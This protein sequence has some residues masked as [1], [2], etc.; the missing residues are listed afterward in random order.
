[1]S[2]KILVNAMAWEKRVA[3]I[4][5]DFVQEIH[6]ERQDKLSIIGNIYKG[7]VVRVLPGI[8]AAFIEIGLDRTAFLQSDDQLGTPVIE[9]QGILVQILKDPIDSKGARVTMQLAIS[10]R[11]LVF[12]PYMNKINIS[13]KIVE[14][15]ERTRL[16]NILA[17]EDGT[18]GG[19]IIRTSAEGLG[20]LELEKDRLYLQ[21]QWHKI[22]NKYQQSKTVDI[23][24][25]DLS[26]SLRVLRDLV[27]N[28]TSIVSTD[29]LEEQQK[30]KQ[31][32]VEFIPEFNGR[33]ELHV[34]A[35][36]IFDMYNIEDEIAKAL[37][38]KV[39]LKSGG[40]LIIEQA[41]AMTTIDVNSG[42]YVGGSN[43][44][45]TVYKINIEAASV[46][47]RQ[48]RLRNV[49]GIIII[50]F[51]DM[52]NVEHRNQVLAKLASELSRDYIK[53]AIS[54]VS[55]L[56]LVQMTRKRTRE[57]LKHL[58][59]EPC[60]ACEGNGYRLS[61]DTLCFEIFREITRLTASYIDSAVN[62]LIIAT[63]AVIDKLASLEIQKLAN[64][65]IKLQADPLYTHE[66]FDMV[67]V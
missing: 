34:E 64:R 11:H 39:A 45:D 52:L 19:Y 40:Y 29:S 60:A 8:Q 41:E 63:P 22:L 13:L 32:I 62:L 49:G 27:S 28:N 46:I 58:L 50:D 23:L 16:Q 51:I 54:E 17:V 21:N 3:I 42:A 59:C 43:L 15:Q 55:S 24:Y 67:L 30:I 26:L 47:A 12:T 4:D 37:Q 9:G 56:G 25:H 36:P 31:F 18:K 33:I 2:E 1:M 53:T 35:T 20:S 5:N 65:T 7:K 14:Q 44:E 10:S 48:L 57:S 38:K 66:Q 6:I 61:I